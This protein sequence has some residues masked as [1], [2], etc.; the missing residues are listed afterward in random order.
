MEDGGHG[1]EGKREGVSCVLVLWVISAQTLTHCSPGAF[2]SQNI[3]F[4]ILCCSEALCSSTPP[5]VGR[6]SSLDLKGRIHPPCNTF[7]PGTAAAAEPL[8]ERQH[9]ALLAARRGAEGQAEGTLLKGLALTAQ[10]QHLPV[11]AQPPS[12]AQSQ[13][14]P[15][16]ARSIGSQP[17]C[18]APQEAPALQPSSCWP[19]PR[20]SLPSTALLPA[21]KIYRI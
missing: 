5:P 11:P 12:P 20:R 8:A 2:Y 9:R 4:Q 19:D 15:A 16:P 17:A 13:P 7:V 18:A 21:I 1:K 14:I 3:H 6:G 10:S